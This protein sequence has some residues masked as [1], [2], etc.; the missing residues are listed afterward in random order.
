MKA[1]RFF[2]VHYDARHNPKVELL[3]DMGNGLIEFARWIVLM[4]ILYDVD[5]LY[6]LTKKGKR[7]YLMKELEISS[8]EELDEF[9]SM[10]AECDLIS[11]ELLELGHVVS[12]GVSEQIEYYK[13][14]SEVAKK[15]AQ[16]RWDK[17]GKRGKSR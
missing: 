8:D 9:L 3:R 4:S 12:R 7:K 15:A 10:C 13:Q 1:D 2:S 6:D 16:S 5:G 14:K 17:G 11:G